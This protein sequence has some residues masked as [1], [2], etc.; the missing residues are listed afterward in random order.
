M[1]KLFAFDSPVTQ[2]LSQ[3]CDLIILNLLY[4]LTSLPVFTVGAA[5]SAMYDVCFRMNTDRECG[6]FRSY[7]LAFRRDFK[8]T[9]MIWLILLFLLLDLGYLLL[10]TLF[11]P[12]LSMIISIAT[13]ILL[14]IIIMT[15]GYIFP[16]SSRFDTNMLQMIKNGLLL[17]IAYL[18]RTIVMAFVN[19]LPYV[20][21]LVSPRIF[22]SCAVLFP[23]IYFSG[24]A[25][26]N[27][28]LLKKVFLSLSPDSV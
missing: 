14:A 7:F 2:K 3:L 17:A 26:L 21:F 11:K 9:T 5:T 23:L 19:T 25:Y 22:W 18:P 24:A 1:L 6:I 28:Q 16:L 8:Q 15:A 20:L 12:G 4:V 10:L 27:A 13:V